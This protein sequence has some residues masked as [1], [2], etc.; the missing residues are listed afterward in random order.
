M[1]RCLHHAFAN[2]IVVFTLSKCLEPDH[3]LIIDSNLLSKKY[4]SYAMNEN[5]VC[6][7]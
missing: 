1:E 5:V 7:C 6:G 2:K 4:A 3:L